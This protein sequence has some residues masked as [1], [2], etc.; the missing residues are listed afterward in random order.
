MSYLM[1]R[2]L[3][4]ENTLMRAMH[5]MGENIQQTLGWM[6]DACAQGRGRFE[7]P[8]CVYNAGNMH[9]RRPCFLLEQ[10]DGPKTR[11]SPGSTLRRLPQ[12]MWALITASA[13]ALLSA[14][15]GQPVV[16]D[17]VSLELSG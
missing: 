10:H 1:T 17:A 8:P 13:L 14:T 12:M 9:Q 5:M 2:R 15:S 3:F 6:A 7:A 4:V 11:S 16:G